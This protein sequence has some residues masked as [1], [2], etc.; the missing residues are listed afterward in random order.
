MTLHELVERYRPHLADETVGVRRSWEEMFRYT[1][2]LCP[3]GTALDAFDLDR[4]AET[5][6]AAGLHRP[7]VEGYIKRWRDLLD[8][9]ETL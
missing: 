5:L 8:R 6:T 1:F 2:K 9:A 4:L 3:A 7:V